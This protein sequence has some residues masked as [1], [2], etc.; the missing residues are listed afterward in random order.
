MLADGPLG[1]RELP[2]K[3]SADAPPLERRDSSAT[4]SR[5]PNDADSEGSV[6]GS[7]TISREGFDWAALSAS[8]SS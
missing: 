1:A 7:G 6:T 2:F 4:S 8:S 5:S 3:C